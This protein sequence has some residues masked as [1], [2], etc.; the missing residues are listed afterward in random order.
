MQND[1]AYYHFIHRNR[2]RYA[3]KHLSSSQWQQDFVP[4]EISRIRH[5]LIDP[6]YPEAREAVGLESLDILLRELSPL[7]T[8]GD[9]IL[10]VPRIP[11]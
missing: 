1:A 6:E 4:L 7:S 10:S 2:I 8:A 3:L 11:C 5:E 9:S